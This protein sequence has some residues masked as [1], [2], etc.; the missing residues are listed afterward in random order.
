MTSI[1]AQPTTTETEPTP[2]DACPACGHPREGHDRI[3]TRF[4]EATTAGNFDRDRGCV[5]GIKS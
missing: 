2:D 5:C 3:A 4:C 1:D